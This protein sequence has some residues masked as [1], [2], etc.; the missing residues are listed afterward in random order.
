MINKIDLQKN[1]K[2]TFELVDL[3][4]ELKKGFYR[5][6]NIPEDEIENRIFHEIVENKEAKWKTYY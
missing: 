6:Q 1:F 2:N 4:L 5:A 3:Y